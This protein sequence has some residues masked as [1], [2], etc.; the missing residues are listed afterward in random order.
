MQSPF[1]SGDKGSPCPHA[2]QPHDG[3]PCAIPLFCGP[4][5][6][7]D[8]RHWP[9][10]AVRLADADGTRGRAFKEVRTSV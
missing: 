5:G 8:S 4:T 10:D 3:S 9:C 6:K 2:R 7:A 1:A